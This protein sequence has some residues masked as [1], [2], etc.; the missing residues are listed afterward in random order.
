MM[1]LGDWRGWG[2]PQEKV[3]K[4]TDW[5]TGGLGLEVKFLMII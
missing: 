1:G 3:G 5:L 2:F 4:I